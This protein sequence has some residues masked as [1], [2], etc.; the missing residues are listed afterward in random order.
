MQDTLISSQLG[1][2]VGV[3]YAIQLLKKSPWFPWIAQH[4][5][6]LNRAVSMVAAFLTSVGFQ[7]A[8]TGNLQAGGT[9]VVQVPALSAIL[10]V[11]LHSLGQVGIQ[12]A[13]YRV[14]VKQ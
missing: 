1:V 4:T 8:F 3:V 7:F 11:L 13:F 12:E 9:L 2:S 10:S 5:D 6:T 14:G